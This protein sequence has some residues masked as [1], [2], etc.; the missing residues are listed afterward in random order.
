M[1]I[2]RAPATSSASESPT[3][4]ASS[5]APTSRSSSAARKM[6]GLGL[7]RP[8]E[9]D[10]IQASTSSENVSIKRGRRVAARVRDQAE[11]EAVAPELTEDRSDVVVELEVR[12]VLPGVDDLDRERA[13]AGP[14]AAHAAHDVLGEPDP[15]LLVVLQLGVMSEVD[16]RRRPGA[17]V[18]RSSSSRPWRAPAVRYPIGPS[19]GPGLGDRE[20]DVDEDGARPGQV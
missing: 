14:A 12:R 11:A 9:P 2:E 20:V 17:V 16:D 3:M 8:C 19:S 18:E 6:L 15:D 10:E 7:T 4:T 13:D 1:P 5:A